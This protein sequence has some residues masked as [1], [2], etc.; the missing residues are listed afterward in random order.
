VSAEFRPSLPQS[1]NFRFR[2]Y[3]RPASCPFT[4]IGVRAHPAKTAR[5]FAR[6]YRATPA[7]HRYPTRFAERF[8]EA[9]P[10]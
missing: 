4:S 3:F 2:R 8:A 6:R 5:I 1:R 10:K 7:A 9:A